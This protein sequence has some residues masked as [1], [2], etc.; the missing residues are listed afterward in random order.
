MEHNDYI[1][2]KQ[3]FF[4]NRLRYNFSNYKKINQ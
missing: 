1:Y 3:K 4:I 2:D